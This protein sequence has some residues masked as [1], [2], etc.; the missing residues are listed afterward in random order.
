MFYRFEVKRDTQPAEWQGVFTVFNPSQR[1][2]IG[3]KLYEPKW[4]AK[5][6]MT[7]SKCWFTTLGYQKYH[8][9]IEQEIQEVQAY[10]P[11]WEFRTIT[12]YGIENIGML[13]KI[14][15]IEIL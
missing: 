6:T 10:H 1:R 3:R 4:Y 14:Q 12:Q 13:G 2:K 8:E 15:C 5:H 9:L 11:N 7:D